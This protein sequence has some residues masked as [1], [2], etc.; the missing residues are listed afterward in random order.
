MNIDRRSI[1]G[2]AGLSAIRAAAVQL[3]V[4]PIA[5]FGAV[6]FLPEIRLRRTNRPI[7]EEAGAELEAELGSIDPDHEPDLTGEENGDEAAA[8]RGQVEPLPEQS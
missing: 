5:A 1:L 6:L 3:S 4:P 7:L 2:V 8:R